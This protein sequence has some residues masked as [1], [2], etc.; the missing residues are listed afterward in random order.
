MKAF[1]VGVKKPYTS[2][3]N[4]QTYFGGYFCTPNPQA[5][6]CVELLEVDMT[7][8]LHAKLLGAETGTSLDIDLAPRMFAGK[9]QGMNLVAVNG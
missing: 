2:Q 1:F 8:A 9:V 5:P 3:K 7:A 4:G 6:E